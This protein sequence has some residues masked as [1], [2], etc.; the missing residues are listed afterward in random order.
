MWTYSW[1]FGLPGCSDPLGI[2]V[3]RG[4]DLF[5][6]RLREI[7]A[8]SGEFEPRSPGGNS[9]AGRRGLPQRAGRHAH[10]VIIRSFV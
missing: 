10:S 1:R 6:Q 8:H 3:D 5:L 4:D 2:G 9:R 7:V